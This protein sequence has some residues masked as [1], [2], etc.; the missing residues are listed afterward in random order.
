LFGLTTFETAM[1][2]DRRTAASPHPLIGRLVDKK[3]LGKLG[4]TK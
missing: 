1:T 3:M 2:P 4:A